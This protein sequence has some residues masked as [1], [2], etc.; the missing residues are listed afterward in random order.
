M[1]SKPELSFSWEQRLTRAPLAAGNYRPRSA[2][3]YP[4]RMTEAAVDRVLTAAPPAFT[5][6]EAAALASELFAVGGVAVEVDS[7]RDQTFFIDGDR[8]AVLK[9]SNAASSY[10]EKGSCGSS[11]GR[12]AGPLPLGVS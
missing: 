11:E 2:A 5:E 12:L 4:D 8:A 7:E 10:S 9:I 3:T 6:D 1:A